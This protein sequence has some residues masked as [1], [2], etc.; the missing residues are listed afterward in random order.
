MIKSRKGLE[1]KLSNIFSANLN[2]RKIIQSW[3]KGAENKYGM[4][5]K[6]SSDYFTN[7]KSLFEASDFALFIFAD[8]ILGPDTVLKYFTNTEATELE[9]MKWHIE[10]IKMPLVFDVSRINDYHYT[11][12]TTVRELMLLKDAQVITYNENTQRT[13][14]HIVDGETEYYQIAL[15]KNAV[16]QIKQSFASNL[17][18]PNTIT[19]NMPED[20]EFRYNF[21]NKELIISKLSSL[22]ILDGY[23]RYIAMQ[24]QCLDDPTFDQEMELRIVQ[25]DE[26]KA[27]RFIW[28][29]DQKTRMKRIDSESMNTSAASNKIV[30]RIN[31]NSSFILSGKIG[32]NNGQINAA[33]FSDVVSKVLLKDVKKSEELKAVV[34][35]SAKLMD[36]METIIECE[37]K[38]LQEH[39][40][41]RMLYLLAY[42]IK[43]GE[44]KDFKEDYTKLSEDNTIYAGSSL[45]QSD[46]TRTHKLLGKD[47]K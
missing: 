19:L 23:H 8:I 18:I 35:Y 16:N 47:K 22:D 3:I 46:I 45:T 25:F 11:G 38:Y 28:Q 30:D 33:E 34:N 37:P 29:E 26:S 9:K 43:F 32:R 4:P 36:G 44:L 6:V 10:K 40:D 39:W 17:F 20:T 31:N 21:K 27:R 13:M 1:T 15:N 7:R 42:L 12:R 2:N 41:R 5:E 14:K 24:K